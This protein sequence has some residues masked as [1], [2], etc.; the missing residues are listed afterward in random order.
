MDTNFKHTQADTPTDDGGSHI[1]IYEDVPQ[2]VDVTAAQ[3]GAAWATINETTPYPFNPTNGL[4]PNV[5][6]SASIFA[7]SVH[8]AGGAHQG[9]GRT[10][11]PAPDT[12]QPNIS[13]YNL[14]LDMQTQGAGNTFRERQSKRIGK[15]I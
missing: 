5:H 8:Y 2:S 13:G 6:T 10:S 3:H 1:D 11:D 4:H 14:H 12:G 15:K 9:S 7:E